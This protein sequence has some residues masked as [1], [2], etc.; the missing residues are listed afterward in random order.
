VTA[1]WRHRVLAFLLLFVARVASGQTLTGT[2]R[3]SASHDGIPGAVIL[4]LADTTTVAR[5]IT[6]EL[7]QYRIVRPASA[8]RMRVVRIGFRP[9]SID[10][11]QLPANAT[12]VNVDMPSITT[13]LEPVHVTAAPGCPRRSDQDAAFALLEQA[14]AGLLTTVVARETNPASMVRLTFE[15][16][17]DGNTDRI[18]RQTVRVDSSDGVNASFEAAR[19]ASEFVKRGFVEDSAGIT[20][21]YGPDADVLLDDAF[22]AGYCF[23][24]GEHDASR[25]QQIALV[26][27]AA[28]R[29]SNR[30]DIEGTLWVDTAAR[31]LRDLDFQYRGLDRD[32]SAVHPGGRTSFREMP[33]GTV[34]IDRW[35]LRLPTPHREPSGSAV[36][37]AARYD[38]T[39]T[40]G[41]VARASWSTG[42][43]WFARLGSLRAKVLDSLGKPVTAAVVRLEGTGYVARPDSTGVATFDAL[44]PGPYY[45]TVVDSAVAAMGMAIR[46]SAS[47]IAARDSTLEASIVIPRPDQYARIGCAANKYTDELTPW[48]VIH[49]VYPNDRPARNAHWQLSRDIRGGTQVVER[50][51]A[52]TDGIVHYCARMVRDDIV[53]ISAW[54]DRET[55]N[56]SLEREISKPGTIV[57]IQLPPPS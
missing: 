29:R 16:S 22:V 13:M 37:R 10:L 53:D 25:P 19:S 3:D 7:G 36:R 1:T 51:V 6:N 23:H 40:G 42:E 12:T 38:A 49:I 15:R 17:M 5:A 54:R 39:E 57:T 52:D 35:V 41:E 44:L 45:I 14:R 33:N 24:L 2:V 32:I 4:L 11:R 56:S 50:G 43:L 46:S 28:D 21:F 26:F 47:L 9:R 55:M 30:I 27:N 18:L 20:I 48:L 34:L 8:G 31:A